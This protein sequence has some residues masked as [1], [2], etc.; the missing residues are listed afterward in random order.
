[1]ETFYTALLA[2]AFVAIGAMALLIVA[3][4]YSGQR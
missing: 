3:K 1:M 2:V 4:L